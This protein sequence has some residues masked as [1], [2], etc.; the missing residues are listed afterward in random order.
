[1]RPGY[2]NIIPAGVA[3]LERFGTP[4]IRWCG[5][6]L[7]RIR[8]ECAAEVKRI[9]DRPLQL[10][11]GA[12]NKI[13]SRIYGELRLSD[14]TFALAL[15]GLG[16]EL[17]AT[18]ARIPDAE[19]NGARPVWLAAAEE[20]VRSRFLESFTLDEVASEVRVHP[21]HLARVFRRRVGTSVGEYVRNLR[22]EYAI[23]LLEG[24][25]SHVQ[26]ACEAGFTDQA[27][28]TRVFKQ[29]VGVTPGIYRFKM[30]QR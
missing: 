21:T 28:F 15:H 16:L 26:I 8:E 10:S 9:F 29:R 20:Y 27:H 14:S 25:M 17:L 12:A 2:L 23:E 13:A 19:S 6:E 18:L 11:G 30:R 1:M 7:L 5:I 3:H 4:A 22:I 24:E